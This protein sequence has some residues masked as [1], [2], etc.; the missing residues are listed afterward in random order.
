MLKL[1]F[2]FLTILFHLNFFNIIFLNVIVINEE[3]NVIKMTEYTLKRL[4]TCIFV[5]FVKEGSG[6]ETFKFT[7]KPQKS[8]NIKSRVFTLFKCIELSI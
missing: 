1:T 6:Q 5:V 7:P 3:L 4:Q 2:T 8:N